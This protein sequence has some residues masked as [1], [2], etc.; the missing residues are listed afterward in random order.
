MKNNLSIVLIILLLVVLACST[1]N[2]TNDPA[3]SNKV[4]IVNNDSKPADSV[5]QTKPAISPIQWSEYDNIYNT[6]SNSTDMQKESAWEKFKGK[7]VA[8]QGT[9][10]EVSE[11]TFGGLNLSIK[12]SPKTMTS[13]ILLTLKDDQKSKAINLTKGSK[14]SFTGN[15]K[16]YGG[17]FLPLSMD[18]GIIK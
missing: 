5:N 10:S 6:E 14:I 18:E 9:V 12:M 13:D 7:T 11:G 1:P 3:Q 4:V 17:A 2:D 16:S 15:L 8:W